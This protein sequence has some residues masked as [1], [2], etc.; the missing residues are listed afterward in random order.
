[1]AV[2]VLMFVNRL[3]VEV[4]S[5]LL[6]PAVELLECYILSVKYTYDI[7]TYCIVI[8]VLKVI[9]VMLKDKAYVTNLISFFL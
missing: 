2:Q 4:M 5:S 3:Y 9:N 6:T 8:Y 1:M 7:D